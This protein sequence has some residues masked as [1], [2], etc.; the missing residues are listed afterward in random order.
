MRLFSAHKQR[1]ARLVMWTVAIITMFV[2]AASL[3]AICA[4]P[5]PVS[6]TSRG[7]LTTPGE[8]AEIKKK[9]DRNIEPYKSAV[10]GVLTSARGNF[11][12]PASGTVNCSASSLPQYLVHGAP[13][14]Y[15]AALAY[16]LTGE[17]GYAQKVKQ[18]IAGLYQITGLAEGGDCPLTFGRHIPSWIK[19]P[20]CSRDTGRARKRRPFRTG[21][22][23]WSIRRCSRD[24][25]GA[26][27][28][29]P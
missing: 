11:L 21:L 24:T 5:A 4:A 1:D 10:A 16:R 12:T 15:A 3:V 25:V 9:A 8:L 26:T 29:A 13:L 14:A 23:P 2:L 19:R 18:G 6:G 28:G 20:T 7:Y 22:P 27:I 17:V